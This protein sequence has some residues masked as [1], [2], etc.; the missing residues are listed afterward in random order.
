MDKPPIPEDDWSMLHYATGILMGLANRHGRMNVVI[1]H[2]GIRVQI[3]F[4]HR[5]ME[6]GDL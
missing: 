3:E 1:Y 6:E 4:V 5:E 2:N